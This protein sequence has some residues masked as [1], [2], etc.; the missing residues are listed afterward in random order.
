MQ[1]NQNSI[2]GKHCYTIGYLIHCKKQP[3]RSHKD[4]IT[5][6]RQERRY[7]LWVVCWTTASLPPAYQKQSIDMQRREHVAAVWS[8]WYPCPPEYYYP[9]RSKGLGSALI[10]LDY[11]SSRVPPP[12]RC[13]W[14]V[15]AKSLLKAFH[16]IRRQDRSHLLR[17]L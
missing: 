14:L 10:A 11:H 4:K 6:D 5:L 1:Q 17:S 12:D 8:R 13:D 16:S 15:T 9:A 7:R 2:A 3:L